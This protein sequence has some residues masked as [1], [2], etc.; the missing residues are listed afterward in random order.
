LSSLK[1]GD[2]YSRTTLLQTNN[3]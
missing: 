1:T 3:N 2:N